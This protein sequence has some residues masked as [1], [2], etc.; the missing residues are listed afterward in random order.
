M[1]GQCYTNTIPDGG[2]DRYAFSLTCDSD[3]DSV[4][5][6][7]G[8]NEGYIIDDL[9]FNKVLV[10]HELTPGQTYYYIVH[11]VP[12]AGKRATPADLQFQVKSAEGVK[13]HVVSTFQ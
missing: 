2:I 1:A 3:V 5:L 7:Q 8:S 10:G 9:R 4:T 12:T 11:N 6:E 13:K